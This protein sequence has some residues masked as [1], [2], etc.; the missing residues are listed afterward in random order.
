MNDIDNYIYKYDIKSF[1]DKNFNRELIAK[2]CRESIQK[3]VEY[4]KNRYPS[5]DYD[6]YG[7]AFENITAIISRK[8]KVRWWENYHAQGELDWLRAHEYLDELKR[9]DEVKE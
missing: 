2:E 9:M 8:V 7:H 3:E 5:A 4:L 6:H 1:F